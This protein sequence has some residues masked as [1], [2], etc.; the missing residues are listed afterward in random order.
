MITFDESDES[1]EVV[2]LNLRPSDNQGADYRDTELTQVKNIVLSAAI[3][4]AE[5]QGLKGIERVP[6]SDA[7][8][9]I[10]QAVKNGPLGKRMTE[11]QKVLF[12][13]RMNQARLSYQKR[14][15]N[16]V[17]KRSRAVPESTKVISNGFLK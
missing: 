13:T 1:K 17:G 2:R 14:K 10:T 15:T 8:F 12:L 11:R 3:K 16:L 5:K 4:A 9:E 6:S 7:A